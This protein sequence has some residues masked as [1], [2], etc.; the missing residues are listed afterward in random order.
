MKKMDLA[1][2]AKD[3]FTTDEMSNKQDIVDALSNLGVKGIHDES[4]KL[5]KQTQDILGKQKK[6]K[7]EDYY[8]RNKL[9][10]DILAASEKDGHYY[11]NLAVAQAELLA[12]QTVFGD[13]KKTSDEKLAELPDSLVKESAASLK[14]ESEDLKKSSEIVNPKD[15]KKEKKG[16]FSKLKKEKGSEEEGAKKE[17]KGSSLLSKIGAGAENALFSA[18]GKA[19]ESLGIASPFAKKG[20]SSLKGSIDKKGGLGEVL[21]KKEETKTDLGKKVSET[22]TPSKIGEAPSLVN[23]VKKLTPLAKKEAAKD[24]EAPKET[25]AAETKPSPD[26]S[27]STAGKSGS[28]KKQETSA[29]GTPG[30]GSDKD[31]Q[32]IKNALTRIAG[33][34]EGT[35]TVSAMDQPFRPDSRRI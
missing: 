28:E 15:G 5:D 20:L 17:T 2:R 27:V 25:K 32:D 22:P 10:D 12:T 24:K 14:K 35:L 11:N 3:G 30:L 1:D 21:S 4:G 6:I 29:S 19:T 13:K 26:S 16:F 7:D 33:L 23:N 18:A 34:L 8:K 9:T 31:M